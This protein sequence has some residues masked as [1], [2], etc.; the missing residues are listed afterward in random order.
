MNPY[1][2]FIK[3]LTQSPVP[4]C[5][6]QLIYYNLVGY[7]TPSASVIQTMIPAE[8][9]PIKVVA[10]GPPNKCRHS[11]YY[12]GKTITHNY[13][14]SSHFSRQALYEFH[15]IY[16]KSKK[17][18]TEYIISRQRD[19]TETLQILTN[20]RLMRLTIESKYKINPSTSILS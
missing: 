11:L 9:I 14:E 15:I 13:D 17:N 18:Q 2:Q 4:L 20:V 8:D 19:M 12:M 5:I 3:L 10:L 16:L 1:E 6:Q 7:G